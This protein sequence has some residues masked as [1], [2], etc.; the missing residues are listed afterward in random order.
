MVVPYLL[1]SAGRMKPGA[2]LAA[3]IAAGVAV[4]ARVLVRAQ[5]G[6]GSPPPVPIERRGLAV[7]QRIP[8]LDLTD[9]FGRRQSL[10]TLSGPKGLVLLFV[11]SADW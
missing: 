2:I 1:K 11:R 4:S 8:P 6:P 5:L 3:V 7:G 9:Q 10:A